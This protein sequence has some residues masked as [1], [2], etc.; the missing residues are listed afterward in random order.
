MCAT[1]VSKRCGRTSATRSPAPHA[2]PAQRGGEAV[3]AAVEVAVAEVGA[4]AVVGLEA[5]RDRVRPLARP[6]RAARL[7]DVEVARNVPAKA[8]VELGVAIDDVSHAAA[9]IRRARR[10]RSGR[11]ASRA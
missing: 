10:R 3:G 6:A 9:R 7:G 8:G 4:R 11:C 2:E 1:A 5:D